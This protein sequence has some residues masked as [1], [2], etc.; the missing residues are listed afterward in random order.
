MNPRVP[1]LPPPHNDDAEKSVIGCLLHGGTKPEAVTGLLSGESFYSEAAQLTFQSIITVADN[2]QGEVDIV[3][4]ADELQ[5]SGNLQI[6]GG[7]SYLYDC[8]STVPHGAHG[9]YYAEI[10]DRHFRHRQAIATVEQLNRQ[11]RDPSIDPEEFIQSSLDC[12]ERMA[13]YLRVRHALPRTISSH[14]EDV[15]STYENDGTPAVYWGIPDIDEMIAGVMPGELVVIGA[16]PSM[17]KT[18]LA[19]QWLD[20]AASRGIPGM[21]ISEEMSAASLANRKLSH[22]TCLPSSE[23][24]NEARRLRFDAKEHFS[25]RAD[26]LVAE[27]V[28]TIAAAERS[29][30]R[31]KQSHKIRIV[32]V[33]YA[34]L[35][36]GCGDTREQRVSDV[37]QRLKACAMKHDLVVLLLAQLNRQI[38]SR[39]DA[40]QLSDLRDSGGLEQDADVALFPYWPWKASPEFEDREEYRIYCRKNRNRGIGAQCVRMRMNAARQRLEPWHPHTEMELP[41]GF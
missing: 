37:S 27:K 33:D 26:V 28:A 30:A 12:F 36:Q 39:K 8:L 20:E 13:R 35:L 41:D 29:I 25:E 17:G 10:V 40:P 2:G 4:V 3:L 31:A 19:M 32:A 18:L 5:R 9:L 15:I 16:R 38:E 14:V 1:E 23:W 24:K 11:V 22:L 6:I 34:Q 7:T 21:I